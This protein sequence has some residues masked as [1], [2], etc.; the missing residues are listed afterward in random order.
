MEKEILIQ[1]EHLKKYYKIK[2]LEMFSKPSY[3]KAVDDVSLDI[4]K[5]EILGIVGESGCGKS[6]LGQMLV[7]LSLPTEG[8][9][10]FE[11]QLLSTRDMKDKAMKRKVQI[12]FQ[13]PYSSLNPKKKIG[14]LIE[15]P[16][17][18]HKI[19]D[20]KSRKK[21]VEDMIEVV[22]LDK[23][24][25]EKYPHELSG[26]QR[27]RASIAIALILNP[28]FIVADEPVS[29]LDVSIQAQIL[30]LLQKLQKERKLTYAFISHN[31][32]VVHYM[33]DRIGV[34]YLGKFV[35]I[36]DV[37]DVYE[38]P[39][40]P[41]TA[42]LLSAMPGSDRDRIVLNG[43]VPS[44]I[45]TKPGCAF[46]SRC[47]Y[48]MPCCENVTPKLIDMGKNRKVRC[49]LYDPAFM[50]NHI[51]GDMK[52]SARLICGSDALYPTKEKGPGTTLELWDKS[53]Q[54]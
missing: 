42:A 28:E 44:P 17:N 19:G 35:E 14:W 5:G 41:Y 49:L 25:L 30:N 26:G 2:N 36:G 22:G 10:S 39:L 29:A 52:V 9:I 47:R 46:C 51:G 18:I 33:S 4:Y 48:A 54:A 32:E 27:Q 15:E 43:E 31:L 23:S 13:D 34:M 3:L 20:N 40:H 7:L 11:N 21:A 38:H 37:D 8:K 50:G 12:I 53:A 16:L 45:D 1:T 24:Y 6:T